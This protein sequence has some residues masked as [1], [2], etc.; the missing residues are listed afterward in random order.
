MN[1]EI[2][3]AVARLRSRI[4]E[5]RG[6]IAALNAD[7]NQQPIREFLKQATNHANDAEGILRG[8]EESFTPWVLIR[9]SDLFLGLATRHR[10]EVE[11]GRLA[12]GPDVTVVG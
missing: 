4:E 1:E 3:V 7:L 9:A 12:Y 6:L 2:R 10:N 5:E 8:V 11:R